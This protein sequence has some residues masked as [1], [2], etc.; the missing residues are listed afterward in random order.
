MMYN[1]IINNICHKLL[2]G[3]PTMPRPRKCR[4][5]CGLPD[6]IEFQPVNRENEKYP[7]I[8]TIDEYETIRLIDKEG[9]S[10]EECS[11]QMEVARTTVQQIYTSARKKIADTLVDGRPLKITGGHYKICNGEIH[12]CKY[13]RCCKHKPCET[14]N[15]NRKKRI[16]MK[17][18]I[19][20]DEDK[21]NVC[22]SFARAP[23]FMLFDETNEKIEL[24]ENTA[25]SAEGGAGLKAAQVLVDQAVQALITVR[26]GE[27]AAQVLQTA[28]ITIYKSEDTDAKQNIQLFK[29]KK[30]AKLTHFHAGFQGIR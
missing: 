22:V 3:E 13:G 26:C 19:P 6:T 5:V 27:N 15:L 28:D 24:I 1:K 25:A 23:Y 11:A 29:E 30:L 14:D 2:Q 8:L 9:M 10:Q 16:K 20:V 18:A 7:V 12:T 17:L 21:K 4:K